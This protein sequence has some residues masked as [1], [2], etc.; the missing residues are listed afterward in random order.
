MDQ[1][2]KD[3]IV[4]FIKAYIEQ[5]HRVAALERRIVE[6]EAEQAARNVTDANRTARLTPL[7]KTGPWGDLNEFRDWHN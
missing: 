2:F 5:R 1:A 3:S 7:A 6:L 4:R